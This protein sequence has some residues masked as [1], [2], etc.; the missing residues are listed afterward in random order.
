M[1]DPSRRPRPGLVPLAAALAFAASAGV[2]GCGRAPKRSPPPPN[3]APAAPARPAAAAPPPAA[4][5]G[6]ATRAAEAD[7]ARDG[8]VPAGAT[9]RGVTA[10]KQAMAGRVAVCGQTDPF[11]DDP[12]VFVPFV[13][14]MAPGQGAPVDRFVGSTT[15]DADRVYEAITGYCFDGGGPVPA[16]N[17]SPLPIP[18]LPNATP[19][20]QGGTEASGAPPPPS[21]PVSPE[22]PPAAAAGPPTPTPAPAP[23]P[24]ETPP[25]GGTVTL[26]QDANIH[27]APHGLTIRVLPAGTA[28]HVFATAPGGWLEV[29]STAPE[30]WVHDSMVVP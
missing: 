17:P 1:Q 30:G 3:P 4:S 21:R 16:L 22:T 20:P 2:A 11:K 13:S 12:A 19:S 23:T 29:G 7:L 5:A 15:D 18:P 9:F 26:R 8:T 27:T 6:T 25:P 28:L 24:A 10:W 14:V